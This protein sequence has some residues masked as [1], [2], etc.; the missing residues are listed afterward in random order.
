MMDTPENKW[1]TVNYSVSNIMKDIHKNY[2]KY[3]VKAKT[4]T[5][6]H[7]TEIFF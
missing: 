1:I 2:Q 3:L 4:I 5:D 7:K 6:L